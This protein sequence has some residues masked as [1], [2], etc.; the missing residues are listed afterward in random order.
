[1]P[2]TVHPPEQIQ[3]LI[4]PA[5]PDCNLACEYCFYRRVS[6]IHG[7]GAHRMS[8]QTLQAVVRRYLKLRLPQS[9]FCWQGGEPTLMGLDFFQRAVSLMQ[10]FGR[11]GQSVSNALQT[12]GLLLDREW[13]VFLRRY[14]FLTGLSLDGPAELHDRY[15]VRSGGAGTHAEVLRALRMM[16]EAGVEFN[17]L[18]VVNALTARHAKTIY[19][20]FRDLGLRHMQFIPCIESDPKTFRPLPFSVT[21]E[22]YADFLCELFDLWLPEAKEGVSIRLFDGLL[23]RELCGNSNLCY[24]D[25]PCGYAP[26]IEHNGDVY[27]CDFFVDPD[28]KLGNVVA[29]PL[30]KIMRRAKARRFR[31]A[32][33][34]LP[35]ACADCAWRTLCRGGCLKDRRRISGGFDS[36]GW[37]CETYKRFLPHGADAIRKLAA[38]IA[39]E[40]AARA[41]PG[42]GRPT[43]RGAPA[44]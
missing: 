15:R 19:T 24:L 26:V 20:Y 41:S 27:P 32:R 37:Y 22:A 18:A 39:A 38:E 11:G 4:K 34:K 7:G 35:E 28:W 44:R 10:Q 43:H 5:G 14:R 1:M 21:P 12:N 33:F 6:A 29:T 16:Q 3:L 2:G 9:V 30:E 40:R 17:V 8:D 23:S 36:P 25:G 42:E 31:G 13:C